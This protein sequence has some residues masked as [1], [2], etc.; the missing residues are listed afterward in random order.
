LDSFSWVKRRGVKGVE[1]GKKRIA[2]VFIVEYGER[3]MNVG[4]NY[5]NTEQLWTFNLN[6]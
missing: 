1:V 6:F 3:V 2:I 5:I 4:P